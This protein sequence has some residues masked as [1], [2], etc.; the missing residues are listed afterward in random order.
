MKTGFFHRTDDTFH[1]G[2]F[3][4]QCL[5]DSGFDVGWLARNTNSDIE[6]VEMLL[7]QPEMDAELFV[8]MGM[9]L[10][11]AFFDPLH[12]MI[13]GQDAPMETAPGAFPP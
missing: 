13:F 7:A 10:G 1:A 11:A 12:E 9:P 5:Q 3:L 2:R 6:A 4:Q 8:R